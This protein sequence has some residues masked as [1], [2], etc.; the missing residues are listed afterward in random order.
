MKIEN[1]TEIE[2]NEEDIKHI[3]HQNLVRLYGEGQYF[4]EF[5]VNNKPLPHPM[6]HTDTV[7][8]HV[9][10]KVKVLIIRQ[11]SDHAS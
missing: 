8:N 5:V 9:F 10:D 6:Y 3:L 4:F 7:D 2:L 1:K 11:G